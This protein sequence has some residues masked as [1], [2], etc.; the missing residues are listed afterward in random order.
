[1]TRTRTR[2]MRQSRWPLVVP[3]AVALPFVIGA[4]AVA[5]GRHGTDPTAERR[6]VQAYAD[7]IRPILKEGGRVVVEE[8]RPRL[9][10]IELGQVTPE[11]FRLE[12]GGWHD[13]MGRLRVR[14]RKV[15]VPSSSGLR[16]AA[17]LYDLALSQ[18]QAAID[19]F[20][21]ASRKPKAELKAAISAAVPLAE[22][23]DRTYD[24]ADALLN[25]ALRRVGLPTASTLP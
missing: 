2:S 3:A 16:Q 20:A 21:A 6:K 9:A 11:Q 12:A 19:G 24:R 22:R 5:V 18:Y 4:I 14:L 1:M 17:L 8:I 7:A 25:A 15:P 10:D 13:A 23:A